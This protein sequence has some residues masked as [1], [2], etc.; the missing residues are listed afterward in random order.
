MAIET[1]SYTICAFVYLVFFAVLLTDKHRGRTKN[2]LLLSALTSAVWSASVASQTVIGVYFPISQFFELLRSLAWLSFL[3][4]MLATTYAHSVPASTSRE[5][6]VRTFLIVIAVIAVVLYAFSHIRL[7]A[8]IEGGLL[9][10]VH[11][12]MAITGIVLVEQLYRAAGI[13]AGTP[14]HRA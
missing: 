4:S 7:Q 10:A 12:M 11:L 2:L 1:I 3:V 13:L 14:Y 6:I 8:E 9:I 5:G